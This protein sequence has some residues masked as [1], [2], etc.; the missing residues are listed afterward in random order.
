MSAQT[1]ETVWTERRALS[2]VLLQIMA[3]V[4]KT[5]LLLMTH[6]LIL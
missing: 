6:I 4:G 2:I 5:S 1:D 3:A